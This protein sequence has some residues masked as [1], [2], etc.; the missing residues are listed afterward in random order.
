[1]T[2]FE[3]ILSIRVVVVVFD[4][5]VIYIYIYISEM[6]RDYKLS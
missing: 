2:K 3:G 6:V 1:M 4:S 5:A